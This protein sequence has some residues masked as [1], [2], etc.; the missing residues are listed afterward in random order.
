MDQIPSNRGYP[1]SLYSDLAS[2][3]EKAVDIEGSGS[4][5]I[6]SV[7][8][9]PGGDV[10]HPI[11]DNTGYITKWGFSSLQRKISLHSWVAHECIHEDRAVLIMI[12]DNLTSRAD[13]DKFVIPWLVLVG[14]MGFQSNGEIYFLLVG[15]LLCPSE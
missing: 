3:Y 4:I 15:N 7:T 12:Q 8:T 1:G 9:M 11:P 6:V 2:R 14:I 10:T 13:Q 5:T